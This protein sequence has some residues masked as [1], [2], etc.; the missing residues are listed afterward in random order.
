MMGDGAGAKAEEQGVQ[1]GALEAFSVCWRPEDILETEGGGVLCPYSP[2]SADGP[3]SRSVGVVAVLRPE[4]CD[5][6]S[7][8]K[9]AERGPQI[10]KGWV[11]RGSILQSIDD[12]LVEPRNRTSMKLGVVPTKR[13]CFIFHTHSLSPEHGAIPLKLQ[14]F[15]FSVSDVIV[16]VWDLLTYKLRELPCF[17]NKI[18]DGGTRFLQSNGMQGDKSTISVRQNVVV[19]L[20]NLSQSL[21]ST[22]HKANYSFMLGY[23]DPPIFSHYEKENRLQLLWK[24]SGTTSYIMHHTLWPYTQRQTVHAHF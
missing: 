17:I 19:L 20:V 9:S 8:L 3:C 15:L 11:S 14:T 24:K 4:T 12:V 21:L 7:A 23:C 1:V 22:F 2:A 6:S 5:Q 10:S 16:V 13:E 18:L